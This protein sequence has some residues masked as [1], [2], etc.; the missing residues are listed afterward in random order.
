MLSPEKSAQ[1]CIPSGY[2]PIRYSAY[3]T[4]A[5]TDY[6]NSVVA[7]PTTMKQAQDKL[8]KEAIEIFLNNGDIFFTS[9]VFNLS[10]K[11]R[12]EVGALLVKILAFDAADDAAL[13]ASYTLSLS[14]L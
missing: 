1:F 10:S 4:Q 11:T 7:V 8:V 14:L 6:V 3:E 13:Q 12:T 2:A 9:S 5:W